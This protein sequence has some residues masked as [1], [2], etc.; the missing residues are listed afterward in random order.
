V[1]TATPA[2]SVP[3]R[4]RPIDDW[5]GRRLHVGILSVKGSLQGATERMDELLWQQAAL[6]PGWRALEVGCGAGLLARSKGIPGTDKDAW[7]GPP[8]VARTEKLPFADAAFHVVL[9]QETLIYSAPPT[10]AL[11]EIARVLKPGGRLVFGE[12]LPGRHGHLFHAKGGGD[13][14][15]WRGWCAA[16]GLKLDVKVDLSIEAWRFYNAMLSRVPPEDK[17]WRQLFYARMLA[18]EQGGLRRVIAW[19]TKEGGGD[20]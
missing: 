8:I 7:R 17:Q 19:A 9:A 20:G 12:F 13:E 4:T 10:P 16:A 5:W 2:R 3:R 14:A 11:A 15:E 6:K 18:I 1:D